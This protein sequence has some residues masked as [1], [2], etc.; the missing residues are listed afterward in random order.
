MDDGVHVIE[1]ETVNEIDAMNSLSLSLSLVAHL[2]PEVR[3]G[4][5]APKMQ[6]PAI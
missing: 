1:S 2:R 3:A 5:A 6:L 4:A